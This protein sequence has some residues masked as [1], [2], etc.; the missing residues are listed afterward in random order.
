[1]TRAA[2]LLLT[3]GALAPHAG[4][5]GFET[6]VDGEGDA[7]ARPTSLTQPFNAGAL[8]DVVALTISGWDLSVSGGDPYRGSRIDGE[9]ADLFRIDIEFAGLVNPPG[10]L[11]LGA[12]TWDPFGFGDRPVYGF[13]ELNIDRERDSGGELGETA[14][15]RYLA[16]AARFGRRTSDSI[17]NRLATS[18]DDLD[19]DF[20]SGP[21]FERSGAEFEF[22]FCG[23]FETQLLNQTGNMDGVMD[24]G[25][26]FDVRGRFFRRVASF[27]SVS[28]MEGGSFGGAYDPMVDVRFEHDTMSDRTTVSFVGALTMAGA[29]TLTGQ[30]EQF[31]DFLVDNHWSVY[32]AA[33][34][35]IDGALGLNGP[36]PPVVAVLL[37]EWDAASPDEH[38]DPTRWRVLALFGTTYTTQG[39]QR[40]V[41]S[42]TGFEET[43][44]DFNGDAIADDADRAA[45]ASYIAAY[46][47]SASDADGLV[48]DRVTLLDPGENFCLYDVTGDHLIDGMDLAVF[49]G[50]LPADPTGDGAVDS[51]DLAALLAMWET[52]GGPADLNGDGVVDSSD[53]AALLAAWGQTAR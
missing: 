18:G 28:G 23:C 16:N 22:G 20:S 33:Y 7:V 30:P 32:E 15:N 1:M 21:Q 14:K 27:S 48:D 39:P 8:P 13:L 5:T 53:L 6:L 36:I 41:W 4:A 12:T 11:G 17:G 46:D 24:E 44:H 38:L 37:D 50:G 43:E 47:G 10:A 45:F 31:A 34:D 2:F 25:E 26:T 49:D 51:S 9:N 40:F 19:S 3:A 29:A 42:D 35:I 52:N